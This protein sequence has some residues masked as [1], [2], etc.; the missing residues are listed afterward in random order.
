M[1]KKP[2]PWFW[3]A[4]G[5]WYITRNGQHIKLGKHPEDSPPPAKRNGKWIVP[6][7]IISTAWV[8]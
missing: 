4:R 7:S 2:S 1:A 3:E 8:P 6:E 5:G